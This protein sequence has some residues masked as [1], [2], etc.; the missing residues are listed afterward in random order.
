MRG[1][2]VETFVRLQIS[3][4]ILNQRDRLC[5]R[6]ILSGLYK[7]FQ[8]AV[9]ICYCLQSLSGPIKEVIFVLIGYSVWLV[10]KPGHL[11]ESIREFNLLSKLFR[12]LQS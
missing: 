2:L 8:A 1:I 7:M 4:N 11:H 9:V 5:W 12:L 3:L 6:L 10:V